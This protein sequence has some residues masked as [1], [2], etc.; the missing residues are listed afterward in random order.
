MASA[1]VL[2]GVA[3][4]EPT[5]LPDRVVTWPALQGVEADLRAVG[6][7]LR[8]AAHPLPSLS[9]VTLLNPDDTTAQNI[10]K[11]LD[12][13]VGQLQAGDTFILL[14]DGHG[15]HVP[16]SDGDDGDGWDEVFIAS[17][18]VPILDDE[19]ASRWNRV[20]EGVTII[21]LVDTCFAD[22]SGLF[23]E[24]PAENLPT[25]SLSV[26]VRTRKGAS[27]F[28]FSASLQKQEAFE[29][30]VGGAYRG[31]LSAS[32]T[33]VWHLTDG[34]RKSYSTLF[35]FAQLLAAFYD[36]RQTTSA[37]FV[38]PALEPIADL[39]PFSVGAD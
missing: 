16:D 28:F 39:P 11:R 10:N 6:A 26:A 35:G 8:E 12:H 7:M 1:A 25:P 9:I 15:Y 2:I 4:P 17:D 18:G 21:G 36:H 31:V 14:L 33:D 34:A 32:L 37:R 24:H 13:Y 30:V 19:F 27:R 38:G 29:T 22:S 3:N 20:P 23:I 5:T